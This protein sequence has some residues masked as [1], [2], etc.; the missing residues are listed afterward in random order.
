MKKKITLIIDSEILKRA[1]KYCAEKK[2]D[3]N[4]L[5]ENFLKKY[6]SENS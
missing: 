1:K 3:I 5:I 4:E 6:I 2:I